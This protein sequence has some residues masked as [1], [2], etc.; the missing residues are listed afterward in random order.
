ML[1]TEIDSVQNVDHKNSSDN[2]LKCELLYSVTH[3]HLYM[4]SKTVCDQKDQKP[5]MN[6]CH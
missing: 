1:H 6:W 4:K 5:T 2:V 3:I